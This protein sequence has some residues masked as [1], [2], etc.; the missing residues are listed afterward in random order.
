M[1]NKNNYCLLSFGDSQGEIMDYVF[2]E[3][4]NYIK[5]ENDNNVGWKS[6]W[7]TRSLLD[8]D[9]VNE[10]INTI[11]FYKINY[12][13]VYIFLSFGCTDIE[14][15]LGY[16]R[17]KDVNVD[18]N[19]LIN[20]MVIAICNLIDSLLLI[21]NLIIIP[22]FAYFPLPL[23]KNYLERYNKKHN[24]HPY[25]DLPE[26]NE[27]TYLW[28]NFKNII[29]NKYKSIDLEK[30]YT[31]KG[32][33]YFMREDEDHHPDFIKL[34]HYLCKELEQFNFFIKPILIEL[35]PH[36]RRIRK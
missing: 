5:Y 31:E 11:K 26:L 27:R 18:T 36:T 14:W 19:N 13:K 23:K 35:Y 6:A 22:I 21:D 16:K 4:N 30:Y 2:Y 8:N 3:N 28:K 33:E 34:Q 12:D 1:E 17:L 10:I 25:Y 29:T 7:S 15:N 24:L 20:D 32:V 9:L